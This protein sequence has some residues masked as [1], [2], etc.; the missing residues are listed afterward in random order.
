MIDK[1]RS[2]PSFLSHSGR[3]HNGQSLKCLLPLEKLP[4]QRERAEKGGE[5]AVIPRFSL[6]SAGVCFVV[7]LCTFTTR[8]DLARF[9]VVC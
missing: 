7:Q 2:R 3:G 4:E 5:I 6:H 9:G 8:R 1:I